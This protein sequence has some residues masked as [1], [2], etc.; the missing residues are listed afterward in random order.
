M[1]WVEHTDL[2]K[3]GFDLGT[4]DP[5]APSAAMIRDMVL[6]FERAVSA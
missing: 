6:S 2:L 3:T 4:V 5:R 1:G